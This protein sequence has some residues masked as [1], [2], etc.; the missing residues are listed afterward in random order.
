MVVFMAMGAIKAAQIARDQLKKESQRNEVITPVEGSA[1]Q[2]AER[3]RSDWWDSDLPTPDNHADNHADTPA[4]NSTNPNTV[5]AWSRDQPSVVS[6]TPPLPPPAFPLPAPPAAN[7]ETPAAS[8]SS[9]ASAPGDTIMPN[10]LVVAAP[11]SHDSKS[12]DI[13]IISF[14]LLSG[15]D[16]PSTS[17]PPPSPTLNVRP[18]TLRPQTSSPTATATATA[19]ALAPN[20]A[21]SA[22]V[23]PQSALS[24][25]N[26]RKR[27][28]RHGAVPTTTIEK[29]I[30]T[31]VY[32][33]D[34]MAK[35]SA[36]RK[37][38]T[39]VSQPLVK[40][41]T[42]AMGPSKKPLANF[43]SCMAAPGARKKRLANA[44]ANKSLIGKE[45]TPPAAANDDDAQ[46]KLRTK[47]SCMAAP[48]ALK[49]RVS[50]PQPYAP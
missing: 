35:R 45:D 48:G 26:M 40:S 16:S 38:A 10:W 1:T 17:P 36:Q 18:S 32:S 22:P 37:K 49:K 7:R 43:E 31:T 21:Q 11:P 4:L 46:P 14:S 30:S 6:P 23:R 29:A 15:S 24:K 12:E 47:Q 2:Y 39:E 5:G 25:Q 33:H 27:N 13:P 42:D 34:S 8:S 19:T 3:G 9:S 50:R 41:N 28:G 44:N 20:D